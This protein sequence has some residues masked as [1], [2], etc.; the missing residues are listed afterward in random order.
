MFARLTTITMMVMGLAVGMIGCGGGGGNAPVATG[1]TLQSISITPATLT[2]GTGASPQFS[3]TGNYSDGTTQNLTTIASW[4]S[5]TASVATVLATTGQATSVA[6]G[7]AAITATA[8]GVSGSATLTVTANATK[9]LATIT[10]TPAAASVNTGTTQQLTATGR[11][12]DNTTADL[13]PNVTWVSSNAAVAAVNSGGLVNAV[14]VGSYV[15]VTASLGGAS[16][17]STLNVTAPADALTALVIAAGQPF[18]YVG[19]RTSPTTWVSGNFANG[20]GISPYPASLTIAACNPANAASID[21]TGMVVGTAMGSCTITAHSGAISSAPAALTI[22][23]PYLLSI[24]I[25][26]ATVSLAAGTSLQLSATGTFQDGSQKDITNTL[27]WSSNNTGIATVVSNTGQIAAV[28]GGTATIT[29]TPLLPALNPAVA[30]PTMTVTVPAS[31]PPQATTSQP[32]VWDNTIADSS[33]PS[34]AS[35]KTTTFSA[36]AFHPNSIAVGCYWYLWYDAVAMMQV[37]EYSCAQSLVKFDV[38]ALAGKTVMSATLKLTTGV[39]GV[40]YVPRSW[41]LHALAAPWSGTSVTWKNAPSTYYVASASNWNPPT[42]VGQIYNIDVSNTVRNWVSGAWPNNGFSMG[43][44]DVSFPY[45]ISLD[46]FEFYSSEAGAAYGPQL[47][48]VAQ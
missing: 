41:Y 8:S 15:N 19:Q 44:N 22:A 6:A 38:S 3:A 42:A 20:T 13:T 28:A 11:Y 25:E 27:N 23:F 16:G 10:V 14:A 4:S 21:A 43:I 35:W 9:Q 1:V 5:G 40:G 30:I 12:T 39:T 2:V 26:P 7:S 46:A 34:N 18:V 45:Q 47:I 33:L 36:N 29:A 37:Q 32:L 31:A 48:V 24:K 17:T